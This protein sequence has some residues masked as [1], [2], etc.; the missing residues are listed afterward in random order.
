MMN[1]QEIEIWKKMFENPEKIIISDSDYDEF[2]EMLNDPSNEEQIN[3][4]K[5]I[6]KK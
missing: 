1:E 4:L 6:F 2:I 3:K 5:Q